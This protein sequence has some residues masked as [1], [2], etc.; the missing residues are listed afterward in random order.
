MSNIL[1]LDKK[2]KEDLLIALHKW[3]QWVSCVLY[4]IELGFYFTIYQNLQKSFKYFLHSETLQ[5]VLRVD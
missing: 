2:T 4:R 3:F 5:L 1:K